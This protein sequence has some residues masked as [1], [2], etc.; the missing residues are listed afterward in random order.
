[1]VLSTLICANVIAM[2]GSPPVPKWVNSQ[3][4]ELEDYLQSCHDKKN[5][6]CAETVVQL[7]I[8]SSHPLV[9]AAALLVAAE[10]VQNKR[11]I[12]LAKREA[13]LSLQRK[14]EDMGV[15]LAALVVANALKKSESKENTKLLE[16]QQTIPMKQPE[17]RAATLEEIQYEEDCERQFEEWKKR[18]AEHPD[19][20][21]GCIQQ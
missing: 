1:M 6:D 12:A 3:V 9:K 5:L 7:R 10:L 18:K 11:C 13:I 2:N 4:L 16:N 15:K 14:D 21:T 19:E 17:P 8:R 20:K